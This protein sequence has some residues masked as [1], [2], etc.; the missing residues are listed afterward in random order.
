[1][2]KN[3]S[4]ILTK[5]RLPFTRSELVARPGLQEK[6]AR[7]LS[8]PFTLIT[9]PAGFGKTTLLASYIS[10]L[11]MPVAWISLD[12][13]DNLEGRFLTY[14]V[15][16][17]QQTDQSIGGKAIQMVASPQPAKA[18]VVLTSLI[19][20]IDNIDMDIMLVLDDYHSISSQVIHGA[21]SFLLDHSPHTFHLV[22]V[23][24]SDPPLP[25]AR[26]RARG[27][28][29][30]LR[31]ADLRF[32]ETE[33][34]E[35][36]NDI[37]GFHLDKKSIAVLENRTEGW[38]TGL[39]LAALSLRYCEDTPDFI[40]GFS[41][42][43]RFILD[44]LLEEV[45]TSQSPEIQRFLLY[46][47]VLDRLSAPLCDFLLEI[48]E[49]PIPG[50]N[51]SPHSGSQFHIQSAPVLASLERANLFLT[52]L[53]NERTWYR[54]HHLFTD[55]LRSRL[56][57][58]HPDLIH[59]LHI[60]ACTWLEQEGLI[61][62][63]IHHL[64]AA[65]E[66]ERA[67]ALIEDYGPAHWSENDPSIMQMAN[68]LPLETILERPKLSL[69]QTWLLIT[70]GRIE[71]ATRLLKNLKQK[72]SVAELKPEQSWM[73]TVVASAMAF[74]SRPEKI[75][76]L[77]PDY[78]LVEEIPA[79]ESIL[80]NITD[81][82]YVMTLGR[83]GELESAVDVATKCVEKGKNLTGMMASHSL[84]PFLTR[85]YLMQGRLHEAAALCC[86]NLEPMGSEPQLNDIA[87]SVK[88]DLGEVLY[89]W[90]RLEEA[91][92]YIRDGLQDN[93]PWQN[94]MSDGFGL[95][96]LIRVLQAKGDYAGALRVADKFETRL[97]AHS[98]PR[99]FDEDFHTLKVRIQLAS[100]DLETSFD[101][102]EKLDHGKEFN[103]HKERYQIT[104]AHI[105]LAQGRYA[106]TEELL[107]GETPPAGSGSQITREL[108]FNLLLAVAIFRQGR[109]LEAINL[110]KSC[111]EMAEPEGYIRI[112][113]DIGDPVG[114]LLAAYLQSVALEN[115]SFAHKVL[116]SFSSIHHESP[117]V[118]TSFGLIEPLTGRE[119]EVLQLLAL[120]NTN[121]QIAGNLIIAPGTVK[122]HTSS[123][124]RKLEVTNRTE[125]V[126]RSKQ[127]GI[128]P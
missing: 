93:E 99:E 33:V 92:Q 43:N 122:A 81:F 58:I 23:T 66:L 98:W 85:G 95:T 72:L 78:R 113:L 83:Q 65:H 12:K 50:E 79:E 76:G 118:S 89:E 90:N 8:G 123:I 46:T 20:D 120:G 41:G 27:Q 10:S 119:F 14:L 61:T 128:L 125:A 53:D 55:L 109:L 62:E 107:A 112:F 45:L 82:L 126:A 15:A 51:R 115:E 22:I 127:L 124:Y 13:D 80:R 36:M 87:G 108:E 18:D 28:M 88:I 3:D 54:Y 19:N 106:E 56:Q 63:A 102:A 39:Q 40:E 32:T 111:L 47:S 16:A 11:R 25:L 31:S 21:V 1:M 9:A 2:Q 4:L 17:L 67:A 110:M 101:W 64:F 57:Q 94:I 121:I 24:R 70:Q 74:L 42:T 35:F 114:E 84:V 30:E 77:L 96:A 29:T 6:I 103:L 69:H 86:A 52:P 73:Q 75:S 104:L 34:A 37:M 59:P 105:R 71:E 117:P 38:I 5:L 97:A 60:R 44:Y 49:M 7:G 91:E 68:T 100:G 116:D 48:D 26:L